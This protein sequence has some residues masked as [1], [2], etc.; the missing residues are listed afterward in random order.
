MTGTSRTLEQQRAE[1][2]WGCV[3]DVTGDYVNLA[4]G[5]PALVMGN[6][7]MQALAFWQSKSKEKYH[8]R[9]REQVC[10][11]LATR[12]LVSGGSYSTAMADL[13]SCDPAVYMRA[14]EEALEILRWIRQLASAAQ[15]AGN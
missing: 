5:A 7:L 14:T 13:H 3:A 2:A 9:L 15:N 8:A 10:R 4:K 11:W 12:K 6:G 1:F